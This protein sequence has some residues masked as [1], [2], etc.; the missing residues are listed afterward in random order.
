MGGLIREIQKIP[1]FTLIETVISISIISV[2]ISI[3]SMVFGNLIQN[4]NSLIEYKAK[5]VLRIEYQSFIS[6]PTFN[7]NRKD[8]D[9][10]Y[11]ERKINFYSR[12]KQLYVVKLL[13]KSIKGD[14]LT[15]I[16]F[17]CV[18]PNE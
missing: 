10:F 3:A 18:N 4:T 8:F 6:D 16:K 14:L 17:L 2:L 7:S 15:S 11:V 9:G 12:K 1:G 5:T 13:A